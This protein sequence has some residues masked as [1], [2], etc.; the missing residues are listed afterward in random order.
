MRQLVEIGCR[1]GEVLSRDEFAARR[2][3]AEQAKRAKERGNKRFQGRQYQQ[4][5]V[6]YTQAIELSPEP[7]HKDV[8]VFY[9]NRAQCYASLEEYKLAEQDCDA[10][11]A[12]VRCDEGGKGPSSNCTEAD[13]A[14]R[15]CGSM[16]RLKQREERRGFAA[17]E[18]RLFK[19]LEPESALL[20][21]MR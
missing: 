2:E 4:A 15:S 19:Q 7:A 17:Y 16:V 18:E 9:G 5:I 12:A 14:Q 13:R 3:A 6:E 20:E 11:E 1:K 21:G 8:A 10:L